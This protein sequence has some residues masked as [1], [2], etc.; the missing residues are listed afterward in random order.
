VLLHSFSITPNNRKV[1]AFIK[2][3][4]LDVEIQQVSFKDRE[5]E[6]AEYLAIN[7]MGKV[8]S[9]EDGD[10]SLWES[11]AILTY[12][13]T[14]FP[15]TDALPTD[16]QGR[17]NVD[18]W[19]HW[20]SCHLMPAMGALKT[21][22]EKGAETIPKLLKILEQQLADKEY[23]CGKLSIADFAIAAYTVT[24]LG[25]KLDYSELPNVGAWRERMLAL[26]GFVETQFR[27]PRQT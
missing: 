15:E 26:K 2:H 27:M 12:L 20:Q 13:A 16:P 3:F 21:G 14:M 11:N 8:P 17:A 25:S 1:E 10:F 19:L 24:K 22:D 9:L 4:D 7:P 23:V 5:T 18:R 6:S